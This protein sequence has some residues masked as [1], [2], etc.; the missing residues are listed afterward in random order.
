[1]HDFF[2]EYM[3][4]HIAFSA[5]SY[6]P[7]GAP[8]SLAAAQQYVGAWGLSRHPKRARGHCP[9]PEADFARASRMCKNQ[10]FAHMLAIPALDAKS[11]IGY[12]WKIPIGYIP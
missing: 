1:L 3:L 4:Q 12:F 11:P 7:D 9:S 10:D 6:R 2:D 5:D 8:A